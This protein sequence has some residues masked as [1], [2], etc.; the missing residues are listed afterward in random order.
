MGLSETEG[1]LNIFLYSILI[2]LIN[3]RMDA[4]ADS[5]TSATWYNE[6]TP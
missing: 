5:Y 1:L 2:C 4:E 3:F 6:P